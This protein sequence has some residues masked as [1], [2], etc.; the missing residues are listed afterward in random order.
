MFHYSLRE[1]KRLS[2]IMYLVLAAIT[3]CHWQV[4]LKQQCISHSSGVWKSE[5][6]RQCGQGLGRALFRYRLLPSSCVL[7]WQKESSLVLSLSSK[8]TNPMH[9]GSI[10]MT[11]LPPKGLI[12][13]YYHSRDL[14]STYGLGDEETMFILY[15]HSVG[16][17][18]FPFYWPCIYPCE[19]LWQWHISK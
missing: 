15:I 12:P 9:E 19:L 17:A 2:N 8:T 10:L 3:K 5:V 11:Q 18:Y 13:Y 14:I 16:K 6:R 1:R 4:A 7:T